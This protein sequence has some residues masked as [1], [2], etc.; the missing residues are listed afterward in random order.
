MELGCDAVMAASAIA[1]AQ[2]PVRMARAMRAGV[3]AGRLARTA[4][5]I[6]RRLYA[7]ASTSNEGL[8]N[9]FT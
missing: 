3:E 7:T 6:P 5:R 4:G 9:L 8:P 1:R 2:D